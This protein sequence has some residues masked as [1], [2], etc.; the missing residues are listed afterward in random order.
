[1]CVSTLFGNN[2]VGISFFF[3][4]FQ[5]QTTMQ[6]YFINVVSLNNILVIYILC[7]KQKKVCIGGDD[8]FSPGAEVIVP[9]YFIFP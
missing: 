4:L 3:L 6:F 2:N 8:R 5:T 1:M 7:E 9:E